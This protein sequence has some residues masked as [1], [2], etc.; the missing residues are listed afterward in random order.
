MTF[1]IN[2]YRTRRGLDGR[3]IRNN[4]ELE[5]HNKDLGVTDMGDDNHTPWL[6][7]RRK[8][9]IDLEKIT[10]KEIYDRVVHGK[11]ADCK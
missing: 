4:R 11:P 2:S 8:D 7:K 1:Y 6:Q 5:A 3:V 9:L 10:G